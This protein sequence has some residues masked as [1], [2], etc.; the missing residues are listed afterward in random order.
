MAK[1]SESHNGKFPDPYAKLPLVDDKAL[2][3]KKKKK[4]KKRDRDIKQKLE[5]SKRLAQVG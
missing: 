3:D 2:K 5:A 1:W 4:K